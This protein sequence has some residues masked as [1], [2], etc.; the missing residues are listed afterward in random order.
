MHAIVFCPE[1][2]KVRAFLAG[3]FGMQ[4]ADPGGGRLI[5]ALPPG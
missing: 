4:P 2:G 5:F 3:I 1:T